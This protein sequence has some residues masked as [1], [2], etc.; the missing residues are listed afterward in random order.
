MNQP[1]SPVTPFHQFTHDGAEVLILRCGPQ[2]G[3]SYGGFQWPLTVGAE[4][5]APDW[6]P[7][8]VCG[9]GLHGWAWGLSFGD[10]K[11]PDWNG[12]WIVFGAKPADVVLVDGKVKARSGVIRFVGEWQAATNFILSGQI[13]WVLHASSGASSAT[14]NRG[15]SSAT[16]YRGASSATGNSGASSATGDRGASS[17][18][19]NR[20]ASSATG[21][22]GASSA[23]GYR[24]ASSAT[25]NS[26]ASSATG[27]RGASSATGNRGASSATGDSGA[28]SAT[29][30]RGASSATGN[31]S[32][33]VVTGL[34]GRAR[35]G[36]YGVIALAFYNAKA[37]RQEMRCA[38]IG[39][40]KDRQLKPGKWYRLDARGR[41]VVDKVQS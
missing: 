17:A 26:G 28:S 41:F 16:G 3:R 15:A 24:G 4:V 37:K 34:D 21:D 9:G 13:A 22:S 7:A 40:G 12:R 29:G 10:G 32:A 1:E 11:E 35:G 33:A 6:N 19:G 36:P 5:S 18:T 20:G 14:G 8:P 23:T 38:R 39:N 27:Y 25:G 2:D 31:A 30:Y